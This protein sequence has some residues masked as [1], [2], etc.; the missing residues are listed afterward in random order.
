MTVFY[1]IYDYFGIAPKEFFDT[2]AAEP[3]KAKE[4]LAISN[5]RTSEQLDCLIA[6]ANGLE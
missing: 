2:D 6:I 3:A 5:R 4:L 1:Y